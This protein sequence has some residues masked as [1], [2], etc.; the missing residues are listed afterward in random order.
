MSE[1]IIQISSAENM[2]TVLKENNVVIADF[3]ADWCPPCKLIA[4]K[5]DA[6]AKEMTSAKFCKVNVDTLGTLGAHYGI[7][8]IPTFI[9]FFKGQEV[10]RLVGASIQDIKRALELQIAKL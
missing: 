6:L 5:F 8:S 3:Y 10:N 2:Q 4:P 7:R 9:L 1:Q